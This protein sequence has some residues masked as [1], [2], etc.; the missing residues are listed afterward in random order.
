MAFRTLHESVSTKQHKINAILKKAEKLHLTTMDDDEHHLKIYTA[1]E[2]LMRQ[3][4]P[5][6]VTSNVVTLSTIINYNSKLK[7]FNKTGTCSFEETELISHSYNSAYEFEEQYLFYKILQAVKKRQIIF[8]FMDLLNYTIE[9]N[10]DDTKEYVHHSVCGILNPINNISTTS[11]NAYD[12]LYF[13]SH[14]NVTKDYHFYNMLLST[15]RNKKISLPCELDYFINTKFTNSLNEYLYV[16]GENTHI[17]YNTTKRYNYQ[18]VNLQSGDN[19]GVCFAFPFIIWYN[20]MNEFNSIYKINSAT[21]TKYISSSRK[22]LA[23]KKLFQFITKAFIIYD[24]TFEQIVNELIIT[25]TST[26]KASKVIEEYIERKG[27]LFL[28]KII[29]AIVSF[30]G[31]KLIKDKMDIH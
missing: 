29:G 10:D 6:N 16:Y 23:K 25:P 30:V 27:T 11:H 14:G 18:Y 8:I 7:T 31:Q 26:H 2:Q 9:H 1:I 19:Y 21:T 4:N 12:F 17:K 3:K 5:R 24:T 22:L 15:R 20:I 28:K 13:N